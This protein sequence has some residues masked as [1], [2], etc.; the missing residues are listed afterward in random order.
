MLLLYL[1]SGSMHVSL[2]LP[3]GLRLILPVP[4]YFIAA[5]CSAH[6]AAYVLRFSRVQ[7]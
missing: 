1:Y 3:V 4:M 6:M 5:Q 2:L 7:F